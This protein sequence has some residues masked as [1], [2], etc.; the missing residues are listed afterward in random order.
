MT[1]QDGQIHE[2]EL[3]ARHEEAIGELYGA[4]ARR[5][6]AYKEFWEKLEQEEIGHASWIR[7]LY[8]KVDEGVVAF[9][10]GRFNVKAIEV[11]LK[12]VAQWT[13]QAERGFVEPV[14]AL[15]I[16]HELENSLIEKKHL[17]WF[18]TDNAD[19]KGVI[20][21]LH[22][23]TSEHRKRIADELEKAKK[24]GEAPGD[25]AVG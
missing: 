4:Y 11:S 24:A 3:L 6:P 14:N 8:P 21:R 1:L 17:D 23:A 25:T 5:F 7:Q 22:E 16:A 12:Y 2:L 15:S 19:I 20:S 9:D 10:D 13:E 18:E